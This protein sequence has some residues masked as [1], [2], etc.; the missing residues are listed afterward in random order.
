MS[1]QAAGLE[2]FVSGWVEAAASRLGLGVA[3]ELRRVPTGGRELLQVVV[4]PPATGPLAQRRWAQVA[5]ALQVLLEAALAQRGE[6]DAA[7]EVQ[8]V[9]APVE[10]RPPPLVEDRGLVAAARALAE[11]AVR[12]GRAFALGPM[13][14][15]DRRQVHQA[16]GDVPEVWTQS[17]GEGIHRRLWVV[18]KSLLAKAG[19]P[20]QPT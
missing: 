20:G 18:P 3:F 16:L 8:L 4:T 1:G 15:A 13:S 10:G 5:H 14:V 6:A 9:D 12:L 2:P 11:S 19:R 17:Q 7:V